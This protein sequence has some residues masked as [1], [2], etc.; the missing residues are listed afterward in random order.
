MRVKDFPF[1]ARAGQPTCVAA[2]FAPL[3][4]DK[5]VRS[6]AQQA[7]NRGCV[8]VI[9]AGN[10]GGTT[11]APGYDEALFVGAVNPASE[12]ASFSDKG[13]FVSMMK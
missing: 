10:A 8:V 12:I 13:P 4:S 5:I 3:W 6:A 7:F 2:D 11:T 9:S 1:A